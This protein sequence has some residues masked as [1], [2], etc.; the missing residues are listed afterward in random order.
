MY[1]PE[2]LNLIAG[3][4]NSFRT[5]PFPHFGQVSSG[6]SEYFTI[7]SKRFLHDSHSYSYKGMKVYPEA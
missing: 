6:G 2:P 1:Q 4:E 5:G 3:D 7:F